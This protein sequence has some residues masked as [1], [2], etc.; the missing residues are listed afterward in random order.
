MLGRKKKNNCKA[1]FELIFWYDSWVKQFLNI[2]A[3]WSP[4]LPK[5]E[6]TFSNV[7]VDHGDSSFLFPLCNAM[8]KFMS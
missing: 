4:H 7:Y 1:K 6:K 5:V 3:L 2:Y 8:F